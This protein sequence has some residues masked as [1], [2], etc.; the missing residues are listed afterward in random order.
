M[1]HELCKEAGVTLEPTFPE[2]E[3]QLPI[4]MGRYEC[5]DKSNTMFVHQIQNVA[6]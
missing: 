4:E 3:S 1:Q 2:R 5:W 6:A